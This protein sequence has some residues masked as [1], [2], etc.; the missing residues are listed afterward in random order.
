MPEPDSLPSRVSATSDPTT[1]KELGVLLDAKDYS[2]T[3]EE[4]E[5]KTGSAS[6]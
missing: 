6:D 2:L 4:Y 5:Q 3:A 1:P